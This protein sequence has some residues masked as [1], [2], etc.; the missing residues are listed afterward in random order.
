MRESVLLALIHIFAIVSTINPAGISSRGK[1]ILRSYLRRYLNRELEE[2]YYT[3]F[4]NNLEFYSNELKSVD[5]AEL[6]DDESL[7]SFQITN[8]CRQIKKGLF[9]E[10]RMIVFLQL[11]EFAFEDGM[12][13]EQEKTII[14]IVA[15]TFSISKKEYDNAIAFM[16]GRSYDAVSQDCLLIIESDNP[17][18][19]GAGTYKNYDNWRHIRIKGFKGHLVVLHIE[20]TGTLLITYDGPLPLYFKGRD[21]IACRPYLLERGVNIKSQGIEPI[22]YS[23]IY[24]KFVSRRFPEKVTF[25]GHDIEFRFKNSDNGVQKM[26]FRIDSGNLVGIMGGSGVGKST[27]F[28]ILHGKISPTSGNLYIN[29]YD[30]NS[31]SEELKGLIG[32]VPQDDMLIEELTVYQN[33]YYNARLCFGDYNEN[34]LRNTVEKVLHDLDLYEIRD[35]QVGD[36]MNKKVSGGQRKR[37][38]IGLELMREPVVL[39]VDEPTSGL[40]SSDSA[41]VMNLLRNQALLG[42]LVFAIIHQPSSDIIKMFDRLWVLDKGGYMIYD[43]DPVEALVYFKTETSQANAA[44][45]ECPNCGNVETDNILHI[46]EVK[47]IDSSGLPGKAR[48]VSPQEWYEKYIKKMMPVPAGKP[49]RTTIPPSNF[50]VPGKAKQIRT[51]IE[52][53]ITR[54]LADS[55][56]MMINLI[57]APLLAFILGYISKF[58]ANGVYTFAANKNYP[59][60]MFMGIIVALFLGLTVSAEEIFRDRKILE[61]EKFLNLSRLSYL[62]SKISFLFALSAVQTLSYILVANLIMEVRGLLLQQWIILFSTACFGNLLGLNISAGMRTAVSIYILI[63]LILVPQL[64]LGG[65]MIRFDDMHWTLSRKIYVPVIGDIMVTRWAHEAIS[66]E[67]FRSNKLQKPFFQ[68]DMEISQNDWYASF[69]IP[70]LKVTVDECLAAGKNPDNAYLYEESFEKLAYHINDLS[71]KSGINPGKVVITQDVNGFNEYMAGETRKYLDSLSRTFRLNSRAVSDKR[72]TLYNQIESVIGAEE[73]IKLRDNHYNET[74]ADIVLN[75]M[76]SNKIYDAGKRFIQKADPVYMY[77]GSRWGRAHFYAPFK[78]IGDLRINTLLFNTIMIWAMIMF[79]GVT[80]Y[81]NLLKKFISLL[82]LL[83][84]PILRKY[85]RDLLQF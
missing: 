56:Y 2:E 18:L 52:R 22:Y 26:N 40:S 76:S 31:D 74:L 11:I 25:E 64:L 45:S 13:S 77:P 17:K 16:I 65:V 59:V 14:D 81:Y 71:E 57:E 38:N 48:Q 41:K 58:S 15:R 9:L 83:K 4:E 19:S 3:L 73:F 47:V 78:Q 34:E 30:I 29:G 66:V 32:F 42:K 24:K 67:Q 55:Q 20:S 23:R 5:K 53:N 44:E 8:I 75:R 12:I 80:L 68:Y 35:L 27:L 6:S 49:A 70:N 69:L 28:N 21:I 63:P 46:I 50:M 85:G 43:G 33:L 37:L 39:F 79:L 82:E 7:I 1:K 60:F 84:L 36:I 61:R 51:F 54:K 62:L 72:N 10:E